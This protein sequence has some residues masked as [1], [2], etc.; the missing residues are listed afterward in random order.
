[1]C[2]NQPMSL[3]IAVGG[4]LIAQYYRYLARVK[5]DDPHAWRFIV[6]LEFFVSMEL[7]QF[8][9]YYWIDDC[10]N[11]INQV[12]AV[13]GLVHI[14]FQPFFTNLIGTW[15][16]MA[17][18]QRYLVDNMVLPLCAVA[19][20]FYATRFIGADMFPC[21]VNTDPLC[22]R[23]TCT[24]MGSVHLAWRLRLRAP[25]F[26]TPGTFIHTFF[27][28]VPNLFTGS[29]K[30]SLLIFITG[31]GLAYL[32]TQHISEWAS[33]W[34]FYSVI[35]LMVIMALGHLF[36]WDPT[37]PKKGLVASTSAP[38]SEAQLMSNGKEHA[39]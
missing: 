34:C 39:S 16:G 26:F 25:N 14:A 20:L 35:Q 11:P 3:V 2:F 37:T 21:D 12:L 28:F 7:L 30:Q 4:L 23:D 38:A 36:L 9:Q 22:G 27:M 33:V 8:F 19:G 31:P 6:G 18:Q 1:M 32:I 13:L 24:Y 17:D 10:S 29:W 15:K 5:W